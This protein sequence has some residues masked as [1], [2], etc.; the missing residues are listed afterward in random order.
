MSQTKR[1]MEHREHQCNVAIGIALQAGALKQ[2][3]IHEDCIF[4]GEK[5]AENAYRLG[6]S[7]F[8]AGELKGIFDERREMTDTIKKMIEEHSLIEGCP[9]CEKLMRD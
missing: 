6:N 5:D 9:R 7:K 3:E 1:L 2:C 8:T 4:G